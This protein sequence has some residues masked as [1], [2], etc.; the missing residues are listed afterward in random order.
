MRKWPIAPFALAAALAIMP[1]AEADSFSFYYNAPGGVSG[2]GTLVG[3]N[4]GSGVW[5][6]TSGTGTFDD[7]TITDSIA[8]IANPNGPAN[9]SLSPS[10]Y[11]VY[12]DLLFPTSGPLQLLDEDGLLFNFDGMELN[13]WDGGFPFEEGW[14]ENTGPSGSGTFTI[15]PEP[16]SFLLMGSGL[17]ALAFMLLRKS[18]MS[19][20]FAKA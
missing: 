19:G 8:L 9:S 17:L 15:T 7:G 10:G 11:F 1:S 14:A 4:E 20:L 16:S 6:I 12:D 5:L 3:T 13:L 2:S 18:G